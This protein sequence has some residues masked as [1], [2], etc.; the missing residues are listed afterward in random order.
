[1]AEI[2]VRE[3]AER[4]K[5]SV[6]SVYNRIK[7]GSLKAVE[8]NGQKLVI[9]EDEEFKTVANGLQTGLKESLK[10]VLND[11]MMGWIDFLAKELDRLQEENAKLL[12]ENRRL[13]KK[14]EKCNK[15]QKKVLISYIQELKQLQLMYKPT[16]EIIET[17]TKVKPKKKK[18]GKK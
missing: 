12:K 17:E 18:K 6:Q 10:P 15:E 4:F 1:M 3:Y 13:V 9:I 11:G 2:T 16:E 5:T 8:R 14:L 7:R